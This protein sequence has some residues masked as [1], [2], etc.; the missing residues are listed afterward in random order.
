MGLG[1]IFFKK[2]EERLPQETVELAEDVEKV[3]TNQNAEEPAVNKLESAETEVKSEEVIPAETVTEK[4]E[5]E[6]KPVEEEQVVVVAT[7]EPVVV[8]V[9]VPVEESKTEE[10]KPL[11]ATAEPV[12]EIKET[13]EENKEIVPDVEEKDPEI[14]EDSVNKEIAEDG[15]E[16]IVEEPAVRIVEETENITELEVRPEIAKEI[17]MIIEKAS[18]TAVEEVLDLIKR[19]L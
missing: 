1:N 6:I 14:I 3:L 5:E 18:K 16:E 8:N 7:P 13:V 2:L 15:S 19:N 10:I 17:Q 11:E 12:E 9:E 4:V